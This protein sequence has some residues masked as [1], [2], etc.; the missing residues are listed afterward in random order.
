MNSADKHRKYLRT[1]PYLAFI[2]TF[3]MA[4]SKD[5]LPNPTDVR[6][7]KILAGV[8]PNNDL[9]HFILPQNNDY[10]NIPTDAKNPLTE[11]KVELG[12]LLFFETALARDA[13]YSNGM[14]TYSCA[15]CHVPSAGF[16]PGRAQGIA[17]GGVGFGMNGEDRVKMDNYRAEETDVQGARALSMLNVAYVTN[18]TWS[19]KFGSF[20][21]NEGTEHLWG[22]D[23]P[24]TEPNHLELSGLEAQN[25]EGLKLHRMVVDE[26][27]LDTLGYRQ[28]YDAAFSD[29]TIEERYSDLTTS[30]AIS[31]YLRTL[32]TTKAPFQEWLKGKEDAM[33]EPEKRGAILFYSKAGCYRCHQGPSMSATEFHAIGVN[34]LCD[35]PGS[36]ATGINDIRNMGRG[37]FTFKAV[38]MYKFKVPGIYNISDSPFYFHGSSKNTILEV[39]E[40]FNTGL[41]ENPR[42]PKEQLSPFFHPLNL[43]LSEIEDLVDFLENAITDPDLQRYVPEQVLSQNCFPN[44]DPTSRQELGCQ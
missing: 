11:E 38:D 21:V 33:T 26:Y 6:L 35:I 40:Y 19:G 29:F 12:K 36:L 13:R 7:E 5:S 1:I 15:T 14:G 9:D 41:A 2:V 27:V 44:N 18:S 24:T 32:L 22:V 42:V 34:D 20:D 25:M 4:C 10:N 39:V 17:D 43:S 8:A 31:A 23:D 28:M 37:G 16:M 3:F 30:F